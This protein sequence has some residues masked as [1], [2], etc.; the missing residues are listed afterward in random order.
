MKILVLSAEVWRD[1]MN[2]GNV[3]SNILKGLDADIAQVFC[4]PGNPNN[5]LCKRYYQMTDRMVMRSFFSR[6]PVGKELIYEEYPRDEEERTVAEQPNKKWYAFFHRYRLGIFYA[7]RNFLWNHSNWKN[8]GL[9][10]FIDEFNPDVIFAPCYGSKFMLRLTR[11]VAERTGKRV[12]SYISDDSYTLKQFRLSPYF[13]LNRFSVR[14]Q[15]RKTFPYY[16]LVYTMTETQQEQCERDFGAN[17]RILRKSADAD[18]IPEKSSVYSPIRLIYAGGIYLNRD[19]TLAKIVKAIKSINK[20]GVKM[21][22]DIYTANEILKKHQRW[23]SD[24]VHSRIHSAISLEELRRIYAESD[25]ALHVESFSLKNRLEV[26][27]SFSTKIVDC[28]SSGAATMAVCDRLQGG[29]RYL[30]ET[31]SAL[32]V[33]SLDGIEDVLR[34]ISEHPERIIEY[35]QKAKDCIKAN[36]DE[37]TT[38]AMLRED[39]AKACQG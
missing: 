9:K 32:C 28:L 37:K 3:L 2:G 6:R 10:K 29:Y 24:G 14:R 23:L 33:D 5:V 26:R 1:D 11:F 17:M 36:H 20:N 18:A 25:I 8:D 21:T 38:E 12:I 7:A 31:D 34:D 35:A 19:K 15:L 27:M 30:K 16:S 13:W 22:L 4:N 39:F